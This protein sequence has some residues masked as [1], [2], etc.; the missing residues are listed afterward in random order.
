[1]VRRS[2][3]APDDWL[4]GHCEHVHPWPADPGAVINAG[5]VR[6]VLAL[7]SRLHQ[8]LRSRAP[9]GRPSST[10]VRS[11]MPV[12][13]PATGTRMCIRTSYSRAE[14]LLP[15]PDEVTV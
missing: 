8:R 4:P 9:R 12:G 7:R 14:P 15:P 13:G 3:L 1:M 5:A 10:I 2:V 11:E 6:A